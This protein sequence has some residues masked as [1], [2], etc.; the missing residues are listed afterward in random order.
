MSGTTI[1]QW[2]HNSGSSGRIGSCFSCSNA[3][4]RA[5]RRASSARTVAATW[6]ES[7]TS[8][9]SPTMS[10]TPTPVCTM[11]IS[12]AS[13]ART[14]RTGRSWPASGWNHSA[15]PTSPP[16]AAA[17]TG[18]VTPVMTISTI[19]LR[20]G[21]ML[22]NRPVVNCG[23]SRTRVAAAMNAS[24]PSAPTVKP[25]SDSRV[26]VRVI[27]T[28]T[29]GTTISSIPAAGIATPCCNRWCSATPTPSDT[30]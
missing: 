14:A 16:A 19:R 2:M 10:T 7:I 17:V 23:A 11:R 15:M 13:S 3:T 26:A 6:I 20:S 28:S 22:A 25:S 29:V 9:G 30:L 27:L 4:C 5:N 18:M 12:A 1:S 21:R 24:A 8:C